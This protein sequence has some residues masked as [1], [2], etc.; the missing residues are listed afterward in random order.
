MAPRLGHVGCTIEELAAERALNKNMSPSPHLERERTRS[1]R[2]CR[3][4]NSVRINMDGRACSPCAA[5]SAHRCN[6]RP[7]TFLTVQTAASCPSWLETVTSCLH[8]FCRPLTLHGAM[9]T[10]DE[11]GKYPCEGC[12]CTPFNNE[13]G[14]REH[15]MR[16]KLC[17]KQRAIPWVPP[18]GDAATLCPLLDD[19]NAP[20]RDYTFAVFGVQR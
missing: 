1:T 5:G 2:A 18:T 4:Q 14:L 16:S 12:G 10:P 11:R 20:E 13:T 9:F 8:C 15:L 6:E 17:R 19:L 3:T 7:S